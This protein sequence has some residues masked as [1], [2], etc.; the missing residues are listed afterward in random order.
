MAFDVSGLS[1]YVKQNPELS[2]RVVSSAKTVEQLKGF[3]SL[4]F[5]KGKMDLASIDQTIV[6]GSGANCGR[7]VGGDISFDQRTIEYTKLTEFTTLCYDVLYNTFMAEKISQGQNEQKLDA[8]VFG[9]IVSDRLDLIAGEHD[10]LMWQG[11]VT[12]GTGNMNKYN[13]FIH[14]IK[15]DG[16]I[17][18]ASGSDIIAKLQSVV[19][20]IPIDLRSHPDFRIFIGKDV[21]D[22][23]NLKLYNDNRFHP[24]QSGIVPGTSVAY[25]VNPGL[26]GTNEVVPIRGTNLRV[27]LDH[28]DDATTMKAVVDP[29]TDETNLDVRFGSGVQIT[30]ADEAYIAT[31]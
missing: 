14:V 26:N 30:I 6:F 11:N 28:E 9:Q 7:P 17:L 29:K 24:A 2:G 1:D 4:V 12:G 13:G 3:K 8:E 19:N 20:Q 15:T 18:T 27:I 10:K 25:L 16:T 22:A 5:G 23:I 31:V 21:E